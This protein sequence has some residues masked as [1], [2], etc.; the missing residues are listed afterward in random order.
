MRTLLRPLLR[1]A[2]FPLLFGGAGVAAWNGYSPDSIGWLMPVIV[3]TVL[4]VTFGLERLLP[5]ANRWNAGSG[6]GTD[7]VYLGTT[8][9]VVAIAEAA[10][11][12]GAI[13]LLS[14]WAADD[15]TLWPTRWPFAAQVFLALA[16]GDFLPHLYHRASHEST[17]FLW[18]VHAIHHA[19]EHL[20]AFNFAR[21]HPINAFLTAALTLLPLAV[22]GTPASVLFVAGVLHN[23]HGVLSHAN[24][25]FRLGPLNVVFSMA[26]L[27]RWHHARDPRWANGNYGATVLIWDWLFGTRRY[28]GHG[29]ADDG[30]GLW[31]GSAVP[32]RLRNQWLHPFSGIS[33]RVVHRL[34]SVRCGCCCAAA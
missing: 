19:P 23:V 21:F 4:L 32:R 3:T 2:A 13:A 20:Y 26:E 7:L 34:R 31:T 15:G 12:A 33:E 16:V 30:V 14:P 8:S 10:V 25:D 1:F 11:W 28:P 24:V 29:V 9:V 22:L 17:G 6:A 5:Y 27:H 18:R